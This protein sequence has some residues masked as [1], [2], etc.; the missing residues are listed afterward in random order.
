MQR[1]HLALLV[2]L[3]AIAL[4]ATGCTSSGSSGSTSS[5]GGEKGT[6]T[7]AFE[8]D[9]YGWDPSNQ[10]GY[11]NWQAE[12]VW[13]QLAFCGAD[14]SLSPGAAEKYEVS[15]ENKTFT[16]HLRKGMKFSDGTPVDADAVKASFDYVSK[17]GG[18]TNDYK[19]ITFD[20]PDAQTISIT[21]PDSQPVMD[22]KIC[23]VR[24]APAAWLAAKKFDVPVGSGPYTLDT[25]KTTTGSVYSFKKNEHYWDAK[26]YSYK[27]LVIKVFANEAAAVAAL[28]TS[29]IDGGLVGSSD[30]QQV[31]GSGFDVLSQ[32][33]QTTRLLLTD[34]L[35]KVLKPLGDLKV[36]QAI[37]MVFDK[38]SMA[39]NLYQGLAEPTAQVFRKGTAA[40]IK[41]L[42]DP[43][44]FDVAAAKQLMA[45]AGYANGFDLELPTL[46]GQNF[47]TLMPYVTEQLAKINISVKQ[48]PLSGAN[49][50]GDLLSGKYPVVLW[51]LGNLGNSALQ[52]YIESTP[53]G[54]WNLEH[55]PDAYVDSRWAQIATATPEES[56]KLQKEINQY[57]VD[58]AWFAPMVYMGTNFAYD[59]K[60]VVIHQI[61]DQEA[62]TPKLRDFQ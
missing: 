21:W 10:P 27:N 5:A 18:S 40:Y 45:E 14:G 19:G 1:K 9:P 50:I 8:T 41:D 31:K 32:Q 29:Q 4:V 58:Q 43:Y 46:E 37:N 11:Q 55:Q 30:V 7:L 23:S 16:A 24:L 13:D 35:G 34:H 3:A 47:E 49:A 17:N 38:E 15:N 22:N 25:T 52:I 48:V 61:S 20:S 39:K 53:E 54:W 12:A 2:P 56:A 6:L 42:K 44:P 57:Q 60:K 28:K 51:Q 36:R 33:G 59:G 62:L 26:D